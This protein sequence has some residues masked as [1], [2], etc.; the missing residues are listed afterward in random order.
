MSRLFGTDGVRGV[1]NATLTPELA[2]ALGRSAA[3]VLAAKHQG[4]IYVGKDTRI[5]SD[6]L[7]AALAAGITSAGVDAVLLGVLPTPAVAYL[8]HSEQ[9]AAGVVI[10]ASHNPVE[11][12]GIKFFHGNGYKLPDETEDRIAA[13]LHDND[14]RPIGAAVGRIHNDTDAWQRYGAYLTRLGDQLSG[15]RIVI[16]CANGAAWQVA[17]WVMSQLG[18]ECQVIYAEPDGVNINVNCGSTHP[19][20]LQQAVRRAGA[21]IGLA[22]DG[23]ADRL[24]AVDERGEIVDGDH[25]LAICGLHMLRS[26]RLPKNTIVATVY[27][28]MGLQLTMQKVGGKVITTKAGDRYVLEAMLQHDLSLGGEQSGHIIFHQHST[29]GDGILTAIQLLSIVKQSGLPLSEL[30]A[31]MIDVPQVLI[32]VPVRVKEWEQNPLVQEAIKQAEAALGTNGRLFVR[33]SGTEL[34]VRV[35]AEGTDAFQVQQ[36]ADMVAEVLKRELG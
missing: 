4:P 29:T 28:N 14:E 27:S 3:R 18:A 34:L 10:S 20:A 12:N 26:G 13:E 2:M 30:S 6:M 19:Q 33:T 7:E 5:S 31:Q 36:Q 11:D 9:A 35:L 25:I 23:D 32:N 21:H 24:I 16:D 8:T 1:A 22:H 15:L 17:P